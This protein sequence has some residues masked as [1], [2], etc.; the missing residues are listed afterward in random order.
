MKEIIAQI[1]PHTAIVWRMI[2]LYKS[3][4][5]VSSI[6]K[7]SQIKVPPLVFEEMAMWSFCY[8]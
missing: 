6:T 2:S 8:N 5:N 7:L 3:Y 1:H 4:E